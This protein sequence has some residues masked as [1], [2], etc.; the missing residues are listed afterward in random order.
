MTITDSK[1]S[2]YLPVPSPAPVI[3]NP[4]SDVILRF[5]T[6]NEPNPIP[7]VFLSALASTATFGKALGPNQGAIF[8]LNTPPIPLVPLPPDNTYLCNP[9]RHLNLTS[10]FILLAERGNCTFLRKTLHAHRAGAS[11][12]LIIGSKDVEGN[13]LLRPSAE[14]EPDV[15]LHQVRDMGVLYAQS[16]VG[17]AIHQ[18][19]DEGLVQLEVLHAEGA[20]QEFV[21]LGKGETREGRLA[22]GQW[23]IWNLRVVEPP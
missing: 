3:I 9:L 1:M 7:D 14:L 18:K 11:G 21:Q 6:T 19:M 2:G 15:L 16:M 13:M 8:G 17:E 12:L 10:P 23:E 22:I 5:S 4:P 20:E